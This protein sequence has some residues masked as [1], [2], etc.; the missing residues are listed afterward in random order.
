M[1][2]LNVYLP[3]NRAE[4]R[5]GQL[6]NLGK[7]FVIIDYVQVVIAYVVGNFNGV[8]GTEYY[9][10]L[11][12]VLGERDLVSTDRRVLPP[13]SYMHYHGCISR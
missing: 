12:R 8:P 1:M 5:G 9:S 13:D 11:E 2:L 3:N 10:L 4:N 6:E 7:L